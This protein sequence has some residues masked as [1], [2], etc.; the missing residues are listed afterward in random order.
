MLFR[1]AVVYALCLAV[2]NLGSPLVA[3]AELVGTLQAVES[4]TRADDLATVGAALAR[5]EVRDQMAALGVNPAD[6]DARVARLTD[7]ELR[8]LADRMGEMPAGGDA[9]AVI[10]IVFVVLV[11]LEL[12]GVIDIF[13]KT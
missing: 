8:T 12:V 5:Q 4:S 10:G 3:H 9:L 2:F 7:T 11:I 6:I 1:K 13:K